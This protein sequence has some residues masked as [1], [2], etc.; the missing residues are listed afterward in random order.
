MFSLNELFSTFDHINKKYLFQKS[1]NWDKKLKTR[2]LEFKGFKIKASSAKVPFF[3]VINLVTLIFPYNFF[4]MN[5]ILKEIL[6]INDWENLYNFY[7][8]KNTLNSIN[9]K[10]ITQ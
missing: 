4:L 9:Y 2:E 8:R 1:V 10:L 3:L 6:N 7:A 5:L